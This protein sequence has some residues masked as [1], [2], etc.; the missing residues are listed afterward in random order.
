MLL[1]KINKIKDKRWLIPL[2]VVLLALLGVGI[3]VARGLA[4][5]NGG[6]T[7]SGTVEAVEV[8]VSPEIAGRVL[9]V[10]V[11]K[12]EAV[13]AGEAVLRLEDDLLQTLRQKAEAALETARANLS[14]AQ[15]SLEVSQAALQA[16]QASEEVISGN[17]QAELLA[18]Q[19]ALDDLYENIDVARAEVALAISVANRAVY[20]ADY[21]YE[22][23]SVP[24]NQ[25]RY[26]AEEGAIEMKK[27]LDRARQQFEPYKNAAST[28][29]TRIDLKEAVDE[30][31]AD[32]NTAVR[33]LE[34]QVALERAEAGLA[35]AL[36]E[37]EKL[38]AG[39]NPNQVA[40]LEARIQAARAL[41]EQ[42][43]AATQQA[44]LAVEQAQARQEQSLAAVV[45]ASAELDWVNAQLDKLVLYAPISGVVLSRDIEPGEVIQP[46]VPVITIGQLDR[47][48]ITVYVPEDLYGKIKLGM[49]ARVLVDSFPGE[50][51]AA[52]VVHIA[53][54]AEFTPRNVQTVEG[55]RTTVFAVELSVQDPQGKLKPGM[56]ADVQFGR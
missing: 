18:A 45:Q 33:R 50:S 15:I 41:P 5:S 10:L 43:R 51:F 19:E 24:E 27:R 34:Y 26:T 12:G 52:S 14:A 3:A 49:K 25:A 53:D 28:D 32:Y 36:R 22:N 56:P 16:A 30:A 55:R 37:Q 31:Q 40:I 17:A 38:A 4:R 21:Y 46:G 9:E 23:F 42:A 39:P 7:A 11:E 2:V 29:S 48:T 35:Q 13:G 8:L 20:E 47:L 54:K 1:N 44:R 6:L